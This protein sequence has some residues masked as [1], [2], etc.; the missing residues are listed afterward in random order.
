LANTASTTHHEEGSCPRAVVTAETLDRTVS[1]PGKRV[2]DW[3]VKDGRG[4]G[5]VDEACALKE[6]P[7]LSGR[8][9]V[10]LSP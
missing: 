5:N 6:S 4:R 3:R 2:L 8:K 1:R 9:E 7:Q 10:G